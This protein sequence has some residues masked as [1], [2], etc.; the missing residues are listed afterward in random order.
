MTSTV[1]TILDDAVGTFEGETRLSILKSLFNECRNS[2]EIARREAQ[3]DIDYYH[4]IQWTDA[5]LKELARRRQPPV[6]MNVIKDKIESIC[7]VEEQSDT[8]P[9][10]WARTPNSEQAAE[11]ATDTLRYVCDGERFAKHRIDVLRDMLIAGTGGA[12]VEVVPNKLGSFDIK[13]RK[14]RWETLVYDPFSR[15][16][17]FSDARYLG[18]AIWMNSE[19]VIAM[20]GEASREAVEGALDDSGLAEDGGESYSDRPIG[21]VWS[22]RKR[23]RVLIVELYHIEAGIWMHSIFTGAGVISSQESP[24]RNADGEPTCPIELA[25]AYVNRDNERYGVVRSMLSA[26]DEINHRRSKMLHLL[27]TRQ[28]YRK[29]G[30]IAAN[31][32]Q[33]LRR[34]L[35]KPDGDIVLARTAEWGKDI[36]IIPTSTEFAGQAELL[37]DARRFIDKQGANNALMG[38]GSEHQSGRA[39]LAQQQA[40]LQTLATLFSGYNDWIL[41]IYRQIWARARQF[42]QAPMW[43][44]VTD[45]IGSPKFIQINEPV[46]DAIGTPL[47]NPQTGLPIMRNRIAK[48]DVDLIVDRV[49]ASANLQDEM[50]KELISLVKAS[51]LGATPQVLSALI[52]SSPVRAQVKRQ[53]MQAIQVQGQPDPQQQQLVLRKALAEIAK[54]EAYAM[55]YGASAMKDQAEARKTMLKNVPDELDVA[56]LMQQL[57]AFQAAQNDKIEQSILAN[58]S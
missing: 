14:L 57:Q 43:V 25:S 19:D 30:S 2:T 52:A 55:K 41:R 4:D 12:I 9:K 16:T 46:V 26:Q 37:N 50:F 15:E 40:G 49:V 42:W 39:I 17:D 54:E 45:D 5:E 29:E 28:T 27:N 23:N 36:G 18:S 58:E 31:D 33:T 35:N 6:T 8:S 22:D 56:V 38:R 24:Y 13:I 47:I 3:R 10:A 48:M 32:P 11:V 51:G 21:S 7:G 44:R 34:E 53:L 1:D 20:Y